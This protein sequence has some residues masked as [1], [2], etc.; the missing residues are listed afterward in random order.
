MEVSMWEVP[1]V[2]QALCYAMR[3]PDNLSNGRVKYCPFK[4]RKDAVQYAGGTH[5]LRTRR[6]ALYIGLSSIVIMG[7][8]FHLFA[9]SVITVR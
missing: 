6:C 3:E 2:C 7:K 8:S 9:L 4:Y 5:G 1:T